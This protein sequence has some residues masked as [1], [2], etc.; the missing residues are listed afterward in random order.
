MADRIF[1]VTGSPE[2]FAR[3][4]TLAEEMIKDLLEIAKLAPE[5]VDQIV[6]ALEGAVGF[7]DGARLEQSIRE[8]VDEESVVDSVVGAIQNLR[9]ASLEQTIASLRSWRDAEPG[10][11]ARLTDASLTAIETNL[12]RL[13]RTFPALERFRKARH[14][15]SLTGPLVRQ[16]DIICDARPVFDPEQTKSEGFVT[17]TTLRVEYEA[18]TEEAGC[19]ELELSPGLLKDLVEKAEKAQ[20]KIDI[21]RDSIR[22]WIPNGLAEPVD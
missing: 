2:E 21:L 14:L 12:P 1:F 6:M 16:I 8:W 4:V 22:A 18:Q 3:G 7:L 20:K 9:S 5:T 11:S 10:R 17:Q 19:V 15:A 13:I